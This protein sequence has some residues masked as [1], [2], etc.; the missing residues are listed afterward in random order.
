MTT[1]RLIEIGKNIWFSLTEDERDNIIVY[2]GTLGYVEHLCDLL[3]CTEFLDSAEQVEY[4]HD[5]IFGTKW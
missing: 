1:N 3:G 2:D 5:E 4:L